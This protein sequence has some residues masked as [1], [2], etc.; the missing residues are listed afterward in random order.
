MRM[1]E[2]RVKLFERGYV[3]ASGDM[4]GNPD[5]LCANEC[6]PMTLTVVR[7]PIEE[8]VKA[9]SMSEG[10]AFPD[11]PD[12]FRENYQEIVCGQCPHWYLYSFEAKPG[13]VLL[14][15]YNSESCL[16]G[17]VFLR[18]DSPLSFELGVPHQNGKSCSKYA[19][20]LGADYTTISEQGKNIRREIIVKRGKHW[21]EDCSNYSVFAGYA[22]ISE[23]VDL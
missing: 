21:S 10:D 15:Y 5:L 13:L 19:V 9:V 1:L 23:F 2:Y 11:Q 22:I 20:T 4:H 7:R 16:H 17:F 12:E 14:E 18:T 6:L 8:L 3:I